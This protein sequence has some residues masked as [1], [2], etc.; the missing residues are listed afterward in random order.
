MEYSSRLLILSQT[1]HIQLR[2]LSRNQKELRKLALECHNFI[3]IEQIQ[4]K[5][6]LTANFVYNCCIICVAHKL[7]L[8]CVT[9]TSLATPVN[10]TEKLE[11]DRKPEKTCWRDQS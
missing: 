1:T 11:V 2:Y 3:S 8:K 6:V 5:H 9:A 4:C 10:Y 7:K